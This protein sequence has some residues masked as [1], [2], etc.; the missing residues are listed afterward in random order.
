MEFEM[1]IGWVVEVNHLGVLLDGDLKMF[2]II[3]VNEIEVKFLV[4]FCNILDIFEHIRIQP[5]SE[6]KVPFVR[7]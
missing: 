3:Q 6:Y 1:R 7:E 4:R 5:F 2:L